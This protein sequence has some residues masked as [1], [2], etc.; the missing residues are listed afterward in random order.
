MYARTGARTAIG[1]TQPALSPSAVHI[2]WTGAELDGDIYAQPLVDS[3]RVI[4]ATE[5]GTLYA[6]DLSTGH[7]LWNRH[8]AD[9]ATAIMPCGSIDPLGITGT[10]AID[11]S[12]H[13]VYAVAETT[14]ASHLLSAVD[15]RTGAVLWQR[16]V[17]PPGMIPVNQQ[18]R[19]AL[20]V[21]NGHVY[22]AFGGLYGDCAVYHGWVVG[23]ALDGAGPS[24]IYRVPSGNKAS[25][26]APSGIAVGDDGSLYVATGNGLSRTDYD[27]GNA[28]IRLDLQLH[29][30][31]FTAPLDWASDNAHDRD[32]GSTGPVLLEGGLVAVGAKDAALHVSTGDHLGGI[33]GELGASRICG[34]GGGVYGGMA[35]SG[36]RVFAPCDDGLRAVDVAVTGTSTVAWTGPVLRPPILAY[37]AVWGVDLL[38]GELLHALD[39]ATGHE[40]A[41]VRVGATRTFTTPSAASGFILVG[42]GTHVVCVSSD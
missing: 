6:L 40:L 17:D 3:G 11:P 41:T 24:L 7:Q 14:D 18:Q 19:A 32:L 8:L 20:V 4:V 13:V 15:D 38:G 31:G 21:A 42:T 39:P 33:G 9:P 36:R 12:T 30:S 28:L 25:I 27:H 37:G 29:E 22:V 34:V 5:H 23:V 10:P 16:V 1:P 35:A 2:A 26:W